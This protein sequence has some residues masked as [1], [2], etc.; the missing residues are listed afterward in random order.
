L[1]VYLLFKGVQIGG[2]AVE[3]GLALQESVNRLFGRADCGWITILDQR[4]QDSQAISQRREVSA[5]LHV[6]SRLL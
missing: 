6:R 3:A 2:P 1:S 4:F 5:R